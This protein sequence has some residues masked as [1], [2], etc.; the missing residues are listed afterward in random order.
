M[1]KIIELTRRINEVYF[2]DS[3]IGIRELFRRKIPDFIW[4]YFKR[5]M[6]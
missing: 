2:S 6:V 5:N 1:L 3:S 4:E